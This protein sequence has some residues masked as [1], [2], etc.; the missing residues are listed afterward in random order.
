MNERKYLSHH[1]VHQHMYGEHKQQKFRTLAE[2]KAKRWS[3]Q[4]IAICPQ[5]ILQ[6]DQAM[7][8]TYFPKWLAMTLASCSI[9]QTAETTQ[10]EAVHSTRSQHRSTT[11]VL[12]SLVLLN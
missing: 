6:L 2:E 5:L 1:H 11:L 7:I 8:S 3:N 10:A 4:R 12:S 9:M